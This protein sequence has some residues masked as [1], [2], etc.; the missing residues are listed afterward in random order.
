MFKGLQFSLGKGFAWSPGL[1]DTSKRS[2][3]TLEWR[4]RPSTLA[5]PRY[6]SVKPLPQDI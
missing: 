1:I 3:L 6:E 2:W 5:M 4:M